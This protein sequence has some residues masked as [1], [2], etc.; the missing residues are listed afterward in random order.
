[1]SDTDINSRLHNYIIKSD[2]SMEYPPEIFELADDKRFSTKIMKNG[3]IKIGIFP[4]TNICLDKLLN[5]LTDSDYF[6]IDNMHEKYE[7]FLCGRYLEAIKI[8]IEHDIDIAVFPEMLLSNKILEAV[9]GFLKAQYDCA[10][11][12]YILGTIWENGC[13]KAVIVNQNGELIFE[14]HKKTPF[15][16]EGREE[17]LSY[18]DKTINIIDI[19]DIGRL[20]TLVCKDGDHDN[21]LNC[22][23][24]FYG[25]MIILPSFSPSLDM[26]SASDELASRYWCSTIMVNSCSALC[27]DD[28]KASKLFFEEEKIGYISL[29]A[30]TKN[31]RVYHNIF[32]RFS[33]KCQDCDTLCSGGK[34]I[35]FSF[36]SVNHENGVKTL[37]VTIEDF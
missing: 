31:E 16:Y 24:E 37:P 25:H 29:P 5:V 36:D 2:C 7:D 15:I 11:R 18:S 20:F 22:I 26:K 33:E 17:R 12:F 1:M 34:M 10:T 30:K 14:Q 6:W 9:K 35:D 21:L 13:N 3:R 8:C 27:S 4:L 32:Y 23:R 19:D 28:K